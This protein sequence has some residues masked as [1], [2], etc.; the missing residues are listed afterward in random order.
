MDKFGVLYIYQSDMS[1]NIEEK[2]NI[3]GK[4]SLMAHLA[5]GGLEM[6]SRVTPRKDF[7]SASQLTTTV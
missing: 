4:I 7:Y 2:H 5:A 6:W 3:A 1:C